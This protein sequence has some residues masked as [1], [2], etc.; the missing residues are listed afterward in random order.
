MAQS[1]YIKFVSGSA[2][3]A[4]TLDEIKEKLL[5]YRDQLGQT[6][7]QLGWEYDEAGFPYTIET[8]PEGEGKW[9]YLKGT[10][11]LYRNIVIGVG[12]EGSPDEQRHYVQFVLPDNATHGDK[13]KGN[14]YCKYLG[15]LLKAELHLFNGRTMYFNPRK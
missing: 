2:V 4:L 15:K 6:A 5:H 13:S 7:K 10:N 8:K 1:A 12:S 9:F 11:A 14:E 3:S